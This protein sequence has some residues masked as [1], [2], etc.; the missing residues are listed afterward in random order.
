MSKCEVKNEIFSQRVAGWMAEC[1]TSV[2]DAFEDWRKADDPVVAADRLSEL[3]NRMFDLSSYLPEH[4]TDH[5][6]RA[7]EEEL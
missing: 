1:A 2:V 5:G 3:S 6:W 4:C 7:H